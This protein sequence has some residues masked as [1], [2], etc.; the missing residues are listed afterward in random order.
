MKFKFLIIPSLF[1]VQCALAQN[2]TPTVS[3]SQGTAT[4]TPAVSSP[5]TVTLIDQSSSQGTV[6]YTEG[7][8]MDYKSV[9]EAATLEEE[10]KMATERFSLTKTQQDLW[11]T[12][13]VDR[14]G[15]EKRTKE[16]LESKDPNLSKDNVYKGLRNAQNTFYEKITGHLS[17]TQKS[18]METDRTIMEEKRKR[19]AKLPPPTPTVTV[20]PVDSAA[21]K[22]EEKAKAPAKKSKK[23]KKAVGA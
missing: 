15:V 5:T 6:A 4:T 23:K 3:P 2:G 20:M 19:I 8:I 17:P 14:R 12:I 13:A 9:Y 16:L 7:T 1:V 11:S 22:A 21:I 10:V 18:A